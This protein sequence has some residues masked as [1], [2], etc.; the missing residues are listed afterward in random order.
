MKIEE[1]LER[2]EF[3]GEIAPSIETLGQLHKKHLFSVPFEN[4]NI[5]LGR[6]IKLDLAGIYSKIV[7]ERRGGFCYELNG[8]FSWLLRSLGFDVTCLSARVIRDGTPGPEF[9]HLVLLVTLEERWLVDVGFGESFLEP[10][11]LDSAVPV[12]QEN[13]EIRLIPGPKGITLSRRDETGEW[14]DRY[15]FSLTP[16]EYSDY[17]GMCRHHQTSPESRFTSGWLCSRATPAGLVTVSNGRLIVSDVN[18]RT[19]TDIDGPAEC[20]KLLEEHTGVRLTTEELEDLWET[21]DA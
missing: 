15:V 5:P 7:V 6:P 2:I 9:D 16:R 17:A 19:E 14:M 18:E 21:R 20:G 1:Y 10:L 4:L 13:G 8:L 11:E 12:V 3:L